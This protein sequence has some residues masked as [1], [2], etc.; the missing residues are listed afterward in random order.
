MREFRRVRDALNLAG[1]RALAGDPLREQPLREHAAAR[2]IAVVALEL[3]QRLFQRG[4][5]SIFAFS[6]S[7]RS[8]R[9]QS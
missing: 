9:L 6:A 5:E 7:G 2:Q 3:L 1:L 4:S 8:K